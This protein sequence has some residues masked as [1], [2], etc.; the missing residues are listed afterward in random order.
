VLGALATVAL[1]VHAEAPVATDVLTRLAPTAHALHVERT[2]AL[3]QQLE[4]LVRALPDVASARVQLD[5]AE[6]AALPLDRPLPATRAAV[7]IVSQGR[8]P[9]RKQVAALFRAVMPDFDE[10]KLALVD[11][12]LARGAARFERAPSPASAPAQLARVGPFVVAT[13]S[14]S[15]LRIALGGSLIAN[16]L[17]A[18]LV[19]ARSRRDRPR[20]PKVDPRAHRGNPL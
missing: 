15:W 19:L 3:E 11:A 4:A 8:T 16:V 13:T 7:V 6:Q 17:L 2:R 5:V 18:T 20:Q 14:A 10:T 12:S 1:P 9:D